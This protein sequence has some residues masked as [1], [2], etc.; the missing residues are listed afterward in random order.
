MFKSYRQIEFAGMTAHVMTFEVGQVLDDP[1]W[2]APVYCFDEEAAA[3]NRQDQ[4]TISSSS[5][6]AAAAAA[7]A[8]GLSLMR[9][10]LPI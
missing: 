9:Y 8:F 4:E 6:S 7:A 10:A 1:N 5:S 2:Q 3:A